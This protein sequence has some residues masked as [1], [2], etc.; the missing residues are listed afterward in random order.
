M[1]T[2]VRAYAHDLLADKYL[3]HLTDGRS[4]YIDD[5]DAYAVG[6]L[7]NGFYEE[8]D[9]EPAPQKQEQGLSPMDAATV[10]AMAGINAPEMRE[11]SVEDFHFF[12]GGHD[13]PR[14]DTAEPQE[15]SVEEGIRLDDLHAFYDDINEQGFE[16]NAEQAARAAHEINRAYCQAVGDDSQVPWD[17]APQWQRDLMTNNVKLH[18]RSP[19]TTPEQSHE[20]WM[21]EKAAAGWV[22]GPTNDPGAKTHPCM[23]PYDQLPPEQRV[24]GH[25]FAAVVRQF[26]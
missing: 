15:P 1:R 18:L 19:D 12:H 7:L 14:D 22:Y 5:D 8:P 25:L 20:S 11:P 4:A 2:N 9:P 23:V 17:D 21:A 24:K 10:R 16:V 26:A 13:D 6:N 3:L